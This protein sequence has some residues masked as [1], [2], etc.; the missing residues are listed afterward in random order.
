MEK[1]DLEYR[2]LESFSRMKRINF[3]ELTGT[4][5]RSEM[6]LLGAACMKKDGKIKVSELLGTTG[7][8]AAA[9]S[10]TLRHLEEK[11]LIVRSFDPENRRSVM[12]EVTPEGRE[13]ADAMLAKVHAYWGEVLRRMPEQDLQDMLRIWDL[14][15]NNMEEVLAEQR[16]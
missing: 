3:W 13:K 16:G 2:I 10:R 1:G 15:M 4:C 7:M 12:V 9:V 11:G 8:Q 6:H 14:I 5:C